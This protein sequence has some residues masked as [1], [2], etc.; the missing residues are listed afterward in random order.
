MGDFQDKLNTRK[1]LDLDYKL[2][3]NF[4]LREF[5]HPDSPKR[6]FLK[7]AVTKALQP[8]QAEHTMFSAEEVISISRLLWYW[9]IH[10]KYTRTINSWHLKWYFPQKRSKKLLS[11]ASTDF[12]EHPFGSL[13]KTSLTVTF[14]PLVQE[15]VEQRPTMVTE[16]GAPIGVDLELVLASGILE[17][18]TN[19]D[20]Q[21]IKDKT[22]TPS[23][24][25]F[26]Y[27]KLSSSANYA[28][29]K[30]HFSV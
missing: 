21:V 15:P 6:G 29:E 26:K 11:R 25:Y 12:P 28:A 9:N 20:S 23:I 1:I 19:T 7:T 2:N 22:D 17:G 24:Y 14:H 27:Q 3:W 10:L 18:K 13:R 8:H 5:I 4:S 30:T 16:G